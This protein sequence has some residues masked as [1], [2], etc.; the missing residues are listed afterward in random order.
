VLSISKSHEFSYAKLADLPTKRSR[1]VDSRCD[2]RALLRWDEGLLADQNLKEREAMLHNLPFKK[3]VRSTHAATAS[4]PDA[5]IASTSNGVKDFK[6]SSYS[7]VTALKSYGRAI[8]SQCELRSKMLS[9]TCEVEKAC[10]ALGGSLPTI[11]TSYNTYVP[12]Q[13]SGVIDCKHCVS[14]IVPSHSHVCVLI[15]H[16][17]EPSHAVMFRM[18]MKMLRTTCALCKDVD[19]DG[20]AFPVEPPDFIDSLLCSNLR[21]CYIIKTPLW[22]IQH[23]LLKLRGSAKTYSIHISSYTE[24]SSAADGAFFIICGLFN[25]EC[26]KDIHAKANAVHPHDPEYDILSLT[27]CATK[28]TSV[29][30]YFPSTGTYYSPLFLSNTSRLQAKGLWLHNQCMAMLNVFQM[31]P[32]TS[33]CIQQDSGLPGVGSQFLNFTDVYWIDVQKMDSTISTLTPVLWGVHVK[34]S[35]VCVPRDIA[36]GRTN[37]TSDNYT[38]QHNN[39][40]LQKHF[41]EELLESKSNHAGCKCYIQGSFIAYPERYLSNVLVVNS[42]LIENNKQVLINVEDNSNLDDIIIKSTIRIHHISGN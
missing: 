14:K 23:C 13:T 3:R 37:P 31:L 36:I 5:T 28:L 11:K 16:A 12:Q 26:M 15:E 18:H 38:Q 22:A 35:C 41:I 7:S 42:S 6:L 9:D 39:I 10:Q 40:L 8:I 25:P 27:Y 20:K 24:L 33:F 29:V 2:K 1:D 34:D 19:L 30:L 21:G 17:L 4:V 32:A